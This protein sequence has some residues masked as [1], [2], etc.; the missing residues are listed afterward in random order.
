VKVA[1]V[2]ETLDARRGGAESA[3]GELGRA[4]AARGHAVTLVGRGEGAAGE[5]AALDDGTWLQPIGVTG[6]SRVLRTIQF[7]R[8]ADEFCRTNGFEIVHA[9]TPCF[10]ANV[11]QPRGG[12]YLETVRRNLALEPTVLHRAVKWVDRRLNRRQRFLLLAERQLLTARPTPWVAA[13]S[14]YVQRQVTGQYGVSVERAP[15]IF[16]A[17]DIEPVAEAHAA[18]VKTQWRDELG[19]ETDGKLV[20]FVAHN[21]KLKGLDD[22]LAAWRLILKRDALPGGSRLI[23]VGNGPRGRY[24]K[25][26]RRLGVGAAVTFLPGQGEMAALY[27]AADVLVH[28]TWY[29][30][31]SR[32]VLEALSCGVPVVTT[33]W[34]GAA[35][36]IAE[37]K[38]GVVIETPLDHVALVDG[39]VQCAL[40]EMA[41]SAR[42]AAAAARE[43]LSMRRHAEELT[44][45]YER[46][47]AG[48]G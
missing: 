47:L 30:P 31:C 9:I 24:E 44:R 5:A 11:Y 12:T 1:L 21:F 23:V 16:N 33:R 48:T 39:I 2:Q 43:Q 40:P 45:L 17:V 42:E 38:Q 10:S 6:G 41:A 36:V 7:V 13:I 20:L 4:L 25:R 19:V 37:G 28:P 26:A 14:H 32:V 34:N 8:G 29:D 3:V 35:E 27:A 22:L 15:V 46:V 18:R